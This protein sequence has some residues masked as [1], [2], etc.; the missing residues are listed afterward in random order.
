M[1]YFLDMHIPNFTVNLTAPISQQKVQN[2]FFLYFT[3]EQVLV[4]DFYDNLNI[5]SHKK[6]NHIFSRLNT[7]KIFLQRPHKISFIF[8]LLDNKQPQPLLHQV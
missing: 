4:I 5:K 1:L 6:V 8:T 7:R 2:V 3:L